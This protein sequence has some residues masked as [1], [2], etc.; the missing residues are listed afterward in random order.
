MTNDNS[1]ITGVNTIN[2]RP[3]EINIQ[4]N[5][6]GVTP[7]NDSSRTMYIWMHYDYMLAIGANGVALLGKQWYI[8]FVYIYY[9]IIIKNNFIKK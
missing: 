3:F 6:S 8:L 7:K 5:A 2:A 9:T 1:R 4:T